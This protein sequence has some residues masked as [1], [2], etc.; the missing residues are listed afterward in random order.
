MRNVIFSALLL[1]FFITVPALVQADDEGGIK[2]S[3]DLQLQISSMPEARAMISQSIIFPFLRGSNPLTKDNSIAAVFSADIS[4]VSMNGS[5]EVI[6]TPIAFFLLSGGGRL[7]S[8]WNMPLGN[9]IG[10]KEPEDKNAPAPGDPPRK[11]VISGDAFGGFMWSSWGAGTLQFDLG[12]LIPGDWT[13]ILFQTR[14]GFRYSAYN[15]AGPND[16]W[17][18]ENDDGENQNG[19]TYLASYVLGYQMPLSPVL[20]T[21]AFMAELAKP[22]Y[23]TPGGDIWG[24]NLGYWI[25]SGLFNFSIHP[26]FSAVLVIQMHT[27]RNYE[28]VHLDNKNYYHYDLTLADEG[29]QRQTLFHRAAL[30]LNYRI[31]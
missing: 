19:W 20:D 27:R 4:P 14:H 22:L 9:G 18:F 3:T 13:H 11:A 21:I 8:G 17:V 16:S 29:K 10:I 1:V 15:R 26:R 2:T 23:N 24:E 6:W 5:G 30:L 7:G 12:A 28:V 25:F 31:R